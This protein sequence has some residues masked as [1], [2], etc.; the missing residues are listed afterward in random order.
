MSVPT[1]RDSCEHGSH[2]NNANRAAQ[3][4]SISIALSCLSH[5][6]AICPDILR[7]T[8]AK[9]ENESIPSI[10]VLRENAIPFFNCTSA[11]DLCGKNEEITMARMYEIE[12]QRDALFV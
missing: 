9:Q 12:P 3:I 8:R 5:Q 7:K 2:P 10:T 6:P 11:T 4:A 1:S